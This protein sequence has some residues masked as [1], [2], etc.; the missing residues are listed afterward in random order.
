MII[1]SQDKE[2][3]INFEN[4]ENISIS[5]DFRYRI[6]CTTG[7]NWFKLGEYHTEEECKK[8]FETIIDDIVYGSNTVI[9]MP[10]SG[11]LNED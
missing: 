1:V 3:I 10:Q 4:I 9:Y 6:E 2:T 5:D 11:E 8:V 7:T